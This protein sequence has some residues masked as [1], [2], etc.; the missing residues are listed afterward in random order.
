MHQQVLD[1][2]GI[3]GLQQPI[4]LVWKGRCICSAQGRAWGWE[5][6]GRG[7]KR[8]GHSWK[9][10]EIVRSAHD[11]LCGP[12][13]LLALPKPQV[14]P[15]CSG[16]GGGSQRPGVIYTSFSPNHLPTHSHPHGPSTG[17]IPSL[18]C[19]PTALPL[20]GSPPSSREMFLRPIPT[21][22][23]ILL[24]LPIAPG[25]NTCWAAFWFGWKPR[26]DQ[27][28]QPGGHTHPVGGF[29][30]TSL[31]PVFFFKTKLVA[32]IYF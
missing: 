20:P 28:L 11:L 12:E 4:C 6:G 23:Y 25:R 16:G 9:R 14:P 15:L 24:W 30:L 3:P 19:W 26:E 1:W 22:V 10:M 5:V 32:D 18:V 8:V 31:S 29:S 17:L 27:R 2:I 7:V 21:S 13:R